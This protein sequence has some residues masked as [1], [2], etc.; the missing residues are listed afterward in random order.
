MHC[1]ILFTNR[2][3]CMMRA[4]HL[5]FPDT[6]AVFKRN[7]TIGILRRDTPKTYYHTTVSLCLFYFLFTTVLQAAREICYIICPKYRRVV[8]GNCYFMFPLPH[9]ALA[10]SD[11]GVM[12]LFRSEF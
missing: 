7:V 9:S 11:G 5:L 12:T 4:S 1:F 6:I 2:A 10:Y 3:S 8:H